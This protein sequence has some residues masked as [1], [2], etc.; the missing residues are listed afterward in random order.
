MEFIPAPLSW[1]AIAP[2]IGFVTRER[3]DPVTKLNEDEM[4]A[5]T[6]SFRTAYIE[7]RLRDQSL[8]GVLG[9]DFIHSWP[10]AAPLCRVQNWRD[11]DGAPN[12]W[13]IPSLVLA[14]RG[15]R[16]NRVFTV[17]GD[18]LN[19][20]GKSAGRKG[21]NGVA[22]YGAPLGEEFLYQ[23]GIAQC[24]EHGLIYVDP[25]G[26][27]RFIPGAVP[28]AL[29]AVPETLGYV[30]G[31]DGSIRGDFQEAWKRGMNQSGGLRNL[32]GL[33]ADGPVLRL[34][35][36]G[37]PWE[38]PMDGQTVDA[39]TQTFAAG[40]IPVTALY[41]QRFNQDSVLF[42]LARIPAASAQ[43]LGT[44][45]HTRIIATPFLEAFLAGRD[46]PLPGADAPRLF[47]PQAG[48]SGL[49][50]EDAPFHEAVLQGLARY[51]LPLT[52]AAP[53]REGDTFRETQR[54]SQGWMMSH[55][56]IA[57]Q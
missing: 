54:F 23:D 31:D 28:S 21:A 19:V 52:D 27:G 11:R 57:V 24:F 1:P 34:D 14:I 25:A 43:A 22:G 17:R 44:V 42:L 38:I 6:E 39:D 51:G 49:R 30:N 32:P 40:R 35:F 45:F 9:G 55:R 48:V 20:Y 26:K 50:P 33:K 15:M 53:S 2:G 41:Y 29:Q 56:R 46:H 16:E 13:G 47:I 37:T 10:P 4:K 5:L 12:T 7:G 8:E 3:E 36:S 18:I